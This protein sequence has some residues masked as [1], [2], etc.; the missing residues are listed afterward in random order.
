[1]STRKHWRGPPRWTRA[2]GPRNGSDRRL[3]LEL[4]ASWGPHRKAEIL[5]TERLKAR[6]KTE[7]RKQKVGSRCRP[8][9]QG[10]AEKSRRKNAESGGSSEWMRLSVLSLHPILFP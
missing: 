9:R 3:E 4:C 1:M 2:P 5:K 7:S 10:S 8:G 6:R